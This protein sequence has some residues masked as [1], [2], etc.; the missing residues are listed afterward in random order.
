VSQS[1]TYTIT[2]RFEWSSD[3]GTAD[4]KKKW[5]AVDAGYKFGDHHN[6]TLT[7]GADR[8]GQVCANGVCRVVN[9]FRGV[10]ASVLSYF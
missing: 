7:V 2:V 3:E 4:G 8:G 6:V 9:P 5:L 10:R 1:P